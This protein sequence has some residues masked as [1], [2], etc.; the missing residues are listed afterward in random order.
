MCAQTYDTHQSLDL[1]YGLHLV[2]C[3]HKIQV[4]GA[5]SVIGDAWHPQ[6]A[7]CE[8]RHKTQTKALS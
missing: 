6:L 4:D 3:A 1:E 2:L 8:H 7:F 5:T